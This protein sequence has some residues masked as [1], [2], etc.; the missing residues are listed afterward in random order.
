MKKLP[1]YYNG[2]FGFVIVKRGVLSGVGSIS[3]A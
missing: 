3:I 1:G 2:L